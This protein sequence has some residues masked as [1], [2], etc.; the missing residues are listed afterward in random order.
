MAKD[1]E[2][3]EGKARTAQEHIGHQYATE[4]CREGKIES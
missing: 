1:S 4:V 2:W 3:A